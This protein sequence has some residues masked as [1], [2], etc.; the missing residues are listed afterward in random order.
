MPDGN[1]FA[2]RRLLALRRF[3]ILCDA[4]LGELALLA[5]N[6]SEVKL[7]AGTVVAR[8]GAPL[9]ALHLVLDGEIATTG[10]P[11]VT[12]GPR[13]GFGA[14]EVLAYRSA[15][16]TA[17][18]TR[19]T[20]TLQLLA[21]DVTEVLEDSFGVMLGLVRGLAVAAGR[22]PRAL[23]AAPALEVR[24][25]GLAERLLVLRRQPVFARAPLESLVALAHASDEIA[26]PAGATLVR[27][28]SPGSCLLV[29]VEGTATARSHAPGARRLGRGD[30]IGG[31][32]ML[33]GI[34][35][36]ETVEALTPIR[37]LRIE[38]PSLFDVI[39]DHT[40]LG[41]AILAVLAGDLLDGA[42]EVVH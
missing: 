29:I 36:D 3:P 35:H 25:L 20:T 37:A 24:S 14:L 11:A 2:L 9:D 27:T 23:P 33:G 16:E 39:E 41:R 4:D 15:L 30:P 7:P 31:L 13:Q 38:A 18:A 34:P 12:W 8:A 28:G 40:D 19:D 5:E 32:A 6:V 10:M 17:I 1:P 42:A 26:A 21:P 22:R